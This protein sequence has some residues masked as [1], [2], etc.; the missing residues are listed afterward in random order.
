[1]LATTRTEPTTVF[2]AV[3]SVCLETGD[4][5]TPVG[6]FDLKKAVAVITSFNA[7]YAGEYQYFLSA[8]DAN[9][10]PLSCKRLLNDPY[11]L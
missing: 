9:G 7:R 1:M 8:V 2:Y 3:G 11:W 6:V 4:C 5:S 10:R